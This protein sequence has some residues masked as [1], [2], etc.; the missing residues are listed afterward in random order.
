MKQ[1]KDAGVEVSPCISGMPA[2]LSCCGANVLPLHHALLTC[3]PSSSQCVGLFP[4]LTHVHLL[5]ILRASTSDVVRLLLT[6]LL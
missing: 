1:L 4:S 2:C 3:I 5:F 6:F